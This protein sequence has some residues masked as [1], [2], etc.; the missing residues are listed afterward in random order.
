MVSQPA[1]TPTLTPTSPESSSKPSVWHKL[2]YLK[3]GI[4]LMVLLL[5]P[6]RAG[7]NFLRAGNR[8]SQTQWLT[9]SIE[10]QTLPV[11]IS[12][13]GTVNSER[14][15]NLS[16]KTSGV[17]D[18][19]FVEE[20]DWV[21]QGQLV[22]IMDDSNL[23][24]QLTQMEGQ[25]AQQEANLERLVAGNRPEEIARA[26]A[27]LA[28]AEANLQQLRSGNRPQEIAQASAR[29]QQ[30]QATLKQREADLQRYEQLYNE[31]AISKQTLDL[32]RTDR[33]VAK[34]QVME[35]E[36]ALALQNAGSRPEEIARA[37]AQVEQQQ[38]S[39][40]LLQAGNRTEDI[41]QAEAQVQAARG[42]LETIEA[43]L[44]DTEVIAPFD[45]IVLEKYADEGAFVSPSMS[46]SG[47][48]ASSSSILTLASDRYE[49]KV[50][51]SESQIAKIEPGQSVTLNVD[52]LP[53]EPLSGTVATI[54]P[55]ASVT[56]NVTSFEVTVAIDPSAT[57]RLKV[58][59]NVEAEFDVGNLENVLL[60]P[61][62]A[63]VRQER[64]EGVYV[65]GDDGNPVF[66][67]INTGATSEGLTEV[68]SGLDGDEEVLL[69]PPSEEE[70]PR[71]F[72]F[73]PAPQ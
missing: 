35:A 68:T 61:N 30:A 5:G 62:A 15:I 7:I 72:G 48:S 23:R 52:A 70:K 12:A 11:T 21:S 10:R 25:L 71:G 20:G 39:L 29:L 54:S 43:Q 19:L 16:P 40:A 22:A 73:P 67:T 45:G 9:Q 2:R 66:E 50:N 38:Q 1:S 27:Q 31:G 46:S 53:D 24:G 3:F 13:N 4:P 59:M 33:D 41:A 34:T 17:I 6:G 8:A 56:Q 55:Q 69:N 44:Q 65:L 47:A 32:E 49:V 58:G 26:I 63:V 14:T 18:E 42:S 28:E 37:A 51:L 57:D 64:G 60:V 36:Q